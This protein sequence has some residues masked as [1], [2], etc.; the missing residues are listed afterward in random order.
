MRAGFEIIPRDLSK[1]EL[2]RYF[3][4]SPKDRHEIFRCRGGGNKARFA[5][6]LGGGRFPTSFAT[7]D[8]NVEKIEPSDQKILR[9][10]KTNLKPH[11]YGCILG[12]S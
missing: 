8:T 6:L 4:Y 9:Y 5:L 7:G 10:V 11:S 2:L 12:R 1:E 3:T